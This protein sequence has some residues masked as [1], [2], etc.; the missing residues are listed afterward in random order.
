M[1]IKQEYID[2]IV[3]IAAPFM[4]GYNLYAYGS[5][6]NGNSHEGSDLDLVII[7]KT[8]ESKNFENLDKLNAIIEDSDLPIL[9]DI[10]DYSTFSTSFKNN[11][12]QAK[13]IKII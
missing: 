4:Q 13:K 6:V 11:I 9:V 8:C 10:S 12:K 2:Y 3:S 5:R 1:N 7:C